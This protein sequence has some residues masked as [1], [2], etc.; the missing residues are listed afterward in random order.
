MVFSS[1]ALGNLLPSLS[2]DVGSSSKRAIS[3][4]SSS[5]SFPDYTLEF[6][7]SAASMRTFINGVDRDSR[8]C[9]TVPHCSAIWEPARSQLKDDLIP[10]TEAGWWWAILPTSQ[11]GCEAL[12]PPVFISSRKPL[13]ALPKGRNSPKSQRYVLGIS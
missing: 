3:I 7:S 4:L 12:Q 5:S 2:L 6:G 1:R 13:A 11:C 10:G 9:S 8:K